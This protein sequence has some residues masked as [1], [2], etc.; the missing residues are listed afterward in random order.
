[1][2]P[3]LAFRLPTWLMILSL[4]AGCGEGVKPAAEVSAADTGAMEELPAADVGADDWPWWR[5]QHQG[6]AGGPAAVTSWSDTENVVWK[7]DVPGRGH[8]S[9]TIVGNRVLLAT[10]DEAAETQSVVC[11]DRDSGKLLWQTKVHEGGF[12]EGGHS[13]STHA[14][15]TLACDGQRVFAV[16]PYRDAIWATAL[17]LEGKQLWQREV[18]GYAAEFGYGASPVL[19][20]SYV[21]V[22]ADRESGGFLAALHRKT[23]EIRWRKPRPEAVS[24][25]SYATPAVFRIAGSDHLVISGAN[26]LA[27]YDPASGDERWSCA[28]TA[29]LTVNTPLRAGNHVIAGGGYPQAET[30]CVD[31]TTGRA[32]WR[33]D[34]KI[35]T[36]SMVA[37]PGGYV[38][39]A[40]DEGVAYC[41][42][43]DDGTQQWSARLGGNIR[44]SLVVCGDHVYVSSTNGKT[45]V[46]K[47]D[48][49]R[50]QRVATNQTGD[51]IFATLSISRGR[52][53]LRAADSSSG[54]RRETLYCIGK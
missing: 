20:G 9:P 34:T 13:E 46:F 3:V 27:S 26:R 17:D 6:V 11:F 4:A 19:Y 8:A 12:I 14:S 50:F 31:A 18:G 44:A 32:A 24:Y 15:C 54:Q 51:E 7:A 25:G 37:H 47:A 5:G 43:G 45:A 16:F 52:I 10:A 29:D 23:G 38:Y 39:A 41:W 42:R 33:N 1:M 53:Y 21:I 36:S 2:M 30:L 48:P 28:G 22:A 35:Y 40:T 49:R